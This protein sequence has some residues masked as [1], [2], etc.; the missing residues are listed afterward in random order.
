VRL[1]AAALAAAALVAGCGSSSAGTRTPSAPASARSHLAS[2]CSL[3]TQRILSRY[4]STR[5]SP[6]TAS[7]LAKSCHFQGTGGGPDVI[8]E[9]DSA[10]QPYFRMDREQVEFWQNVEWSGQAAKAAPYPITSLGLGGYWFPLQRRLLTTDGVR[11]VTIKVRSAGSAGPMARKS[12][13]T[14]LAHVYLGA[15]VKPPGY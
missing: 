10:P 5:P 4:G 8:V 9:L 11:L 13:A 1:A 2:A 3:R 15:P 12:L 14:R 7:N 6:F